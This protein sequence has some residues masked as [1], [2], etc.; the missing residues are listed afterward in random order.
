MR[1]PP[2]PVS[3]GRAHTEETSMYTDS[4]KREWLEA[5]KWCKEHHMEGLAEFYFEMLETY[6]YPKG[7]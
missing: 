4:D 3:V 7:R 6:G 5:R 1:V 2:S